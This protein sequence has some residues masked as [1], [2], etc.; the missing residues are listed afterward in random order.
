MDSH[1]VFRAWKRFFLVT[2]FLGGVLALAIAGGIA[3]AL[4]V[5]IG[6]DRD[7]RNLV[8]NLIGYAVGFCAFACVSWLTYYQVTRALLKRAGSAP[9]AAAADR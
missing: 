3:L 6:P 7:P 4:G 5:M 8:G 9:W 1:D 2:T